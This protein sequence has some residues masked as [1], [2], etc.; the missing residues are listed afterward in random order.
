LRPLFVAGDGEP[1]SFAGRLRAAA[2]M[3]LWAPHAATSVIGV[4]FVVMLLAV[5]AWAYTDALAD[6]ARSM[7]ANLGGPVLLWFALRAGAARG[8]FTA[9]R[10]RH[11][12]ITLAQLARCFGGGALMGFGT[13]LIPGSND[14]LILIG[15]PLLWPYAWVAFVTMCVSI[16]AAQLV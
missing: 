10:F 8:G 15:M 16:A 11:T 4:T 6:L 3:R 9:G 5:G 12:P 2:S 13:L 14:G 7:T 1:A